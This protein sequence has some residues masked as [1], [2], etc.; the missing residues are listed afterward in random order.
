MFLKVPN[1]GIFLF[2][3]AV[4]PF[5]THNTELNKSLEESEK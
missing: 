5:P 1:T 3:S 2:Q 4:A